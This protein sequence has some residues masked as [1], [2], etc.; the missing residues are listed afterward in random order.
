MKQAHR[1]YDADRYSD[2]IENPSR[3]RLAQAYIACAYAYGLPIARR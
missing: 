1:Q 2:H 3:K